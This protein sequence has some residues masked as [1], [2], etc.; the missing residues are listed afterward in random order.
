M[1]TRKSKEIQIGVIGGG[2]IARAHMSN[3]CDDRRTDVR[4]LAD[5]DETT[6]QAAGAEYAVPQLTADYREMLIDADLDA[7]VVCTPPGSHCQI[8]LDVLSA[9]KHLLMEK[10]L[11]LDVKQAKRLMRQAQKHPELVVSGCSCRHAR[12]NPK[13]PYVKKLIEA[14]KLGEIYFVHHRSV[15]RQG[16]PGIE[17][18]P[19]AKWFLDKSV[20]GGG[21]L[22]D[23]GVY[24]LSFHLG[25]LGEPSFKRADAFCIN[26][27][28]QVDP[29]TD[30]FT[31]EEHG[32]A[33]MTFEG[34]I[35]Y[36]W[37]RASNAHNQVPH[38]T[39]IYGT[40]GGLRFEYTTWGGGEIEYYYVDRAGKG[41]AKARTLK[42]DMS[43]H[44]K[45]DMYPLGQAF[46]KALKG[47]G[48]VPMPLDIEVKNLEILNKV[49]KA[50]DW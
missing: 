39:S 33:L 29:G 40:K 36:F 46:I 19:K 6:L 22:Y 16:R 48:D 2:M 43:R 42:A 26:G 24:D 7:V 37:E 18:N 13:F 14:G 12:L 4:W 15:G 8:G 27:L 25:V 17:Y 30:R 49:Y 32:G 21:P 50:A 20:A 38:Q 28:D 9:G 10:P 1:A 11:A 3:F 23:W 5:I 35:K 31:V 44:N 45:G 34:G 47:Q 41:N